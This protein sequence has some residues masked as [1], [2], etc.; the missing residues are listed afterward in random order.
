MQ[1]RR[2]AAITTSFENGQLAV[3]NFLTKDNFTCSVGCLEFLAKLNDWH[4][5]EKLFEYFPECD[6]Q[7]VATQLTQLVE[8]NALVVEGTPQ[9]EL[10][11][12]YRE[13]WQWGTVAGFY[14][15]S[16]RNT[17]FLVGEGVREFMRQRKAWRP[18][19]PLYLSNKDALRVIPL[20]VTDLDE[21]PFAL[22]R[23]R[24]SNRLFT[25]E[26][27]S[28][29]A[30]GDCL[31]AG[32]G[33]VAFYDDEDFGHLPI[34][35]TPSGGARNPFE[36]YVYANNVAGLE[37]GFYHYAALER[38]LG[39]IRSGEA[40]IL[41][42]LAGQDWPASAGAIVFLVA[43]FPRCMWKYHM[44]TAYRVVLMEAGF[45]GQNIALAATHHGLSAIPSG[46]F[47]ES[48]IESY[49][50]VPSIETSVILSMNIGVPEPGQESHSNKYKR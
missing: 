21:E 33:I 7:S 25:E 41:E 22:M 20:P 27:V 35:M 31:F 29:Q 45:I 46:A 32:N 38:D 43:N 9:A 5:A 17:P 44:P 13:Q 24:R 50:G 47:A 8:F 36:L 34:T 42:M 14:H 3:H 11:E 15:F 18:S 23:R 37:T 12:K 30:L 26:P 2:A 10:D 16:I 19:P 4:P 39:L 49:L 48:V 6:R 28:I 1:F 40:D